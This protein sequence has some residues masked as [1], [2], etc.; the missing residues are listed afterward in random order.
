GTG[1][2]QDPIELP[3]TSG[4]TG[5][6]LSILPASGI[7]SGQP[8][9]LAVSPDGHYLVVALNTADQVAVI[10]LRTRAQRLAHVAQYPNG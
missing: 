5:Q 2:E 7:G 4:G 1:T 10:D 6:N 3:S 9:G 8:E